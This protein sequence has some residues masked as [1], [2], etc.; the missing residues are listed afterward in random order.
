MSQKS[1][2]RFGSMLGSLADEEVIRMIHELDDPETRL[3][4]ERG[5]DTAISDIFP[6]KKEQNS[7]AGSLVGLGNYPSLVHLA[8]VVAEKRGLISR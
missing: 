2:R 7:Y 1:L 6:T 5:D 3:L 4:V 8:Y